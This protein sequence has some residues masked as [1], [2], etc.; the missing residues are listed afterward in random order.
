MQQN[1]DSTAPVRHSAI[2]STTRSRSRAAIMS[3]PEKRS[4][5]PGDEDRLAKK[6]KWS[7]D[8]EM[9]TLHENDVSHSSDQHSVDSRPQIDPSGDQSM[10]QSLPASMQSRLPS[11]N[12]EPPEEH[13]DPSSRRAAAAAVSGQLGPDPAEQ[14]LR[15]SATP[16]MRARPEATRWADARISA[17]LRVVVC[18]SVLQRHD[19]ARLLAQEQLFLQHP[20]Q[21]DLD[22]GVR[23]L[24]PQYLL[25]PG[26]D[27]PP[28]EHLSV[29]TCC[30][31]GSSSTRDLLRDFERNEILKIFNTVSTSSEAIETIQSSPRLRT[32]MKRHQ[33]EALTM[34]VE[35]EAGIYDRAQFP[36]MW[37]AV[38]SPGGE[39]S[40]LWMGEADYNKREKDSLELLRKVVAATCLRRTKADHAL[41]LNLPRKLER[42]EEVEM[43]RE[44]REI[45]DF[46][47]RFSFLNAVGH[48]SSTVT[49]T[50]ILLLIAMLRLI[51]DHGE[52]LLPGSAIKTWRE[53]D[54]TLLTLQ[55]LESGI[56]RCVYCEREIEEL[57]TAGPIAE[58][59]TCGH[60][61]CD[62]CAA[63]SQGSGS[64]CPKC[65][66]EGSKSPSAMSIS[67][68]A[69]SQSGL[70]SPLKPQYPPS[71]KL[72][73]LLRNITEQQESPDKG[74]R[75]AKWYY[76]EYS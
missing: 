1:I 13:A 52:A 56:R 64:S 15:D 55:M 73:A 63:K 59:P 41:T 51:C 20:S 28:L 31:N 10:E 45:Y 16:Q 14:Y 65:E 61:L 71:A 30:V 17:A 4:P 32:E 8:V 5:L 24:N 23:Y 53:R 12:V 35:K 68:P 47:K 49:P 34:M 69:P 76:T 54:V 75:P 70:A 42:V 29:S 48:A 74:S 22:E 11:V 62:S 39:M 57:D 27:M 2:T 3:P 66:T 40:Y 38:L 9:C 21:A 37:K 43:S 6:P 25:P 44:D 58:E 18:G 50:N 36:A 46:F 67:S 7:H 19:V 72:Q 26:Q 33:M 60:V